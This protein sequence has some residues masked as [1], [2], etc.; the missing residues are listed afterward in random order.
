[1]SLRHLHYFIAVAEYGS[2]T[3]AAEALFV[4]QPALS[5]QIK[6]L[7]TH[8]GAPLFSRSGRLTRLT[9]AGVVYLHYAR[10]ALQQLESGRQAIHDVKDLSRGQLRIALT[11]TFS[12]WLMGPLLAEFSARYP[13]INLQLNELSQEHIEQA[14]LADEAD[15][16]LAYDSVRSAGLSSLKLF[17]E[18]LAVVVSQQHPLATQ[19]TLSLQQLGAQRLILL[20]KNFATR[21]QIDAFLQQHQISPDIIMEASSPGAVCEIVRHSQLVTLLPAPV[22][23]AASGLRALALR[24]AC[25]QRSALFIQRSQGRQTAAAQAFGHLCQQRAA[26]F[27]SGIDPR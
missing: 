1:M 25:L 26:V 18:T 6:L 9:D 11:P 24:Q 13:G 21:S 20:T 12:A 14:L 23:H 2:F 19:R 15:C 10:Q 17:D 8:L 5:Q 16:G 4:S 3:R 7:E 22:A 27:A